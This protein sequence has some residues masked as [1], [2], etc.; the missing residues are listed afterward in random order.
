VISTQTITQQLAQH[1]PVLSNTGNSHAAV[2]LILD[3]A[4]STDDPEIIFIERA[5]VPNDPWSGHIAFPGGRREPGDQLSLDTAVR[6]TEEEIGVDLSAGQLL[7]QLDDLTGRRSHHLVVSCFVFMMSSVGP[8][9]Q[10]HE[11]ADV[12]TQPISRLLET[13]RQTEVQYEAWQGQVF[14]AI[15]LSDH[16][17]P[18][19]WGLTYRFLENFFTLLGHQL[20][21]S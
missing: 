3:S 13:K 4:A 12:F 9:R 16:E 7:G 2:A 18:I 10:N 8:F 17:E 11:V 15:R 21:P 14:P 1:Q 6:E 20:P 19:V 5:R